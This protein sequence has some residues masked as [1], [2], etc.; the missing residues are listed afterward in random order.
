MK[1]LALD[2]EFRPWCGSLS[3]LP[4]LL[5]LSIEKLAGESL[6]KHIST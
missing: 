6:E 4:G 1:A 5:F 3:E 2:W